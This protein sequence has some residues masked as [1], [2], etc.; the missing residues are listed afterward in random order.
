MRDIESPAAG[1]LRIRGLPL[2][3]ILSLSCSAERGSQSPRAELRR[4]ADGQARNVILIV[5]DTMRR[6]RIGIYGG[7]AKTPGFDAFARSNLLFERAYTQAPWTKPSMATL[8]TSLYPSQ[9][10]VLSHPS[11]RTRADKTRSVGV[12]TTDVLS[13]ELTTLAEILRASGFRTAAFVGNPWMR[14]G[15]G[16]EQGF[17]VY[18][19]SLATWEVPGDVVSRAGLEWLEGIDS[20]E[21]FFLYLHFMDSHRPYGPL[22]REEVLRRGHELR[23]D[24]RPVSLET[25]KEITRLV[26]LED[27]RP[28][29]EVGVRPSLALLEMAYDRGIENF[30]RALSMFLDRFASHGAYERTAIIT[31]DHGEALY[32]RG[33]GNHGDGL[34]DDEVVIPLA[35]RL[36]GVTV[37]GFRVGDPIGLIDLIPTL[38]SLLDIDLSLPVFGVSVLRDDRDGEGEGRYIVT[39]GVMHKPSNRA[40]RDDT[41]KLLWQPQR[42]YDDKG[43]ALF[44]IE[45]DP[46]ETRDLLSPERLTGSTRPIF[47]RLARAVRRAVPPFEGPER[48]QRPIDPELLERLRSIGYVN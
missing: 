47:E 8:F 21:R 46:G 12:L 26:R 16:F 13:T 28:A 34:Y 37:E 4:S 38:C 36:P 40:I 45:D 23:S 44:N 32:T 42:G 31:S 14:K 43:H 1:A 20:G 35:A 24:R 22:R 30:D 29:V 9:H 3:L 39:E 10:G 11:I 6:D 7:S 15:F 27:G 48:E 41:Y 17:E 5:N 18:D 25:L 2:L 19:D 33:Y